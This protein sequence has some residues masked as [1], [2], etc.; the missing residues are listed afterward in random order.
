MYKV[1]PIRGKRIRGERLK[2]LKT[3]LKIERG[4]GKWRD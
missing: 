2:W 3:K 4:G 1:E